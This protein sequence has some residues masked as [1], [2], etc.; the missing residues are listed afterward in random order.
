MVARVVDGVSGD[1]TFCLCP[2]YTSRIYGVDWTWRVGLRGIDETIS[3]SILDERTFRDSSRVSQP[4]LIRATGL[5][6]PTTLSRTVPNFNARLLKP[7][8]D[9]ETA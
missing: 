7:S 2:F 6:N 3:F 5:M 9:F 8:I 4:E 1:W